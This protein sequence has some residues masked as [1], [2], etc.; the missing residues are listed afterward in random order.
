MKADTCV[1]M[2]VRFRLVLLTLLKKI[3]CYFLRNDKWYFSYLIL[4]SWIDIEVS[5]IDFPLK[6]RL[7]C[8]PRTDRF[9]L[10]VKLLVY[11]PQWVCMVFMK[12]MAI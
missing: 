12:D 7:F 1:L 10:K 3:V 2:A 11:K 9:K 5:K 6:D 8:H 4:N